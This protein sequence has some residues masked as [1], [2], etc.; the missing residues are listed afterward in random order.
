MITYFIIS[1]FILTGCGNSSLSQFDKFVDGRTSFVG[2]PNSSPKKPKKSLKLEVR[3]KVD[4]SEF[5]HLPSTDRMVSI[6]K[7][8]SMINDKDNLDNVVYGDYTLFQAVVINDSLKKSQKSDKIIDL[9]L[10]PNAKETFD[11][12]AEVKSFGNRWNGYTALSIAVEKK[13]IELTRRLIEAGADPKQGTI[14]AIFVADQKK[15]ILNVLL[16]ENENPN[17]LSSKYPKAVSLGYKMEV[18][19]NFQHYFLFM[20]ILC[21]K[22]FYDIIEP[23][24]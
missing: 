9:L 10:S 6:K 20:Y 22:F 18:I 8:E 4:N 11:L 17:F 2:K 24:V 13:N 23:N 5:P 12:D 3:R 7:L 21:I 1:A 19:H 16:P 14:P 15:E